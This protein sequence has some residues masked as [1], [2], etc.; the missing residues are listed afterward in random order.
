MK[1]LNKTQLVGYLGSDPEII[2][3]PSGN[4]L[5]TL[6]VATHTKMRNPPKNIEYPFTTTWHTVT[7][8]GRERIEKIM[9]QFIKGSHVLVEGKIIYRVYFN[10]KGE[11]R[12]V[13]EINAYSIL[14]L[15]R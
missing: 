5:A 3:L 15:D 4:M 14:N 2:L 12:Y 11:K 10:K 13:T 8:W 7:I 6:S 9:N 1:T